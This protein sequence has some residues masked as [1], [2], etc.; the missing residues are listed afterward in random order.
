MSR[1]WSQ[2]VRK[3]FTVAQC[4]Y[5]AGLLDGEESSQSLIQTKDPNLYY[6]CPLQ[7]LASL[8][9]LLAFLEALLPP[10]R[11]NK[12]QK[13]L[14]K[15]YKWQCTGYRLD[16]MLEVTLPYLVEKRNQAEV[17]IE[18]KATLNIHYREVQGKAGA[19]ALPADVVAKRIHLW[20]TLKAL[21]IKSGSFH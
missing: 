20:E 13:T 10:I 9:G 12:L 8:I 3:E 6:P 19:A 15:V 16:H 1:K 14:R 5:M 11:P 17:L 21:H 4:A 7:P 2:Y 18:M